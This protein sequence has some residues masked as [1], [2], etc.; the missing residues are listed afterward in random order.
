MLGN[1]KVQ[2]VCVPVH[3]IHSKCDILANNDF[4]L[5]AG[6]INVLRVLQKINGSDLMLKT[7]CFNHFDN[8][9]S[10]ENTNPRKMVCF[11]CMRK[12]FCFCN[13]LA[14]P[15]LDEVPKP[16]HTPLNSFPIYKLY[17][18][19]WHSAISSKISWL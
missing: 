16:G 12:Q 2:S 6:F 15:D 4:G 3:L 8:N 11:P 19:K 10:N 9:N 1:L 18:T 7:I 17:C 5:V 14:E 13:G